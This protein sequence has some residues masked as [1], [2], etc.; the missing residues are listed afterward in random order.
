MTEIIGGIMVAMLF[1]ALFG[2][3]SKISGVRVAISVFGLT[4]FVTAWVVIAATLLAGG[5]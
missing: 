1:L 5:E 4:I 2:V 3:I